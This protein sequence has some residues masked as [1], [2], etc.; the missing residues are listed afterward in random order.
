MG[1]RDGIFVH[2]GRRFEPLQMLFLLKMDAENDTNRPCL[3]AILRRPTCCFCLK[4]VP[5]TTKFVLFG[6]HFEP[7]QV[8]LW[9]KMGAEN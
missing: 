4:W 2:F 9:L 3:D 8:L 1:R 6:R 5:K 7:L